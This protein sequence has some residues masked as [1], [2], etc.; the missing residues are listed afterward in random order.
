MVTH[1]FHPL[2]GQEFER[3]SFPHGRCEQLVCYHNAQ[4]QLRKLPI[5]WTSLKP[6]DV[7]ELIAQ[8]RALFRPE[9]LAVLAALV[10]Q[11]SAEAGSK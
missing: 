7:F 3:V 11:L 5:G 9:D 8:G 4:G 6:V 2:R 1:P 10:Q